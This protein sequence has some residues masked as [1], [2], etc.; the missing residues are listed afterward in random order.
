MSK[1][2][3]QYGTDSPGRNL[4]VLIPSISI[5]GNVL[6]AFLTSLI[7]SEN[8]KVLMDQGFRMIGLV[9][10]ASISIV[11]LT[12]SLTVLSVQIAAQNY[13]PRLLEDFLKDPVSKLVISANV[14]AEH[15]PSVTHCCTS[16]MTFQTMLAFPTSLFNCFPCIWQLFC[17]LSFCSFIS[18]SMVSAWKKY[19]VGL[20]ILP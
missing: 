7:R 15:M 2:Y 4:Y 20:Q 14:G 3:Q 17:F 9:S 12:F 13:S 19:F 16:R 1:R 11:T 5:V 10:G 8:D 18:S 6:V